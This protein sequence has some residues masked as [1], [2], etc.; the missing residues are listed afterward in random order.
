MPQT[1]ESNTFELTRCITE[2]SRYY[3]EIEIT[4]SLTSCLII[5]HV[6]MM[7]NSSESRVNGAVQR[8]ND[9]F[10]MQS[11]IKRN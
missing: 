7:R 6:P 11:R 3:N 1:N 9:S 2:S 5:T 10:K 4:R 8:T